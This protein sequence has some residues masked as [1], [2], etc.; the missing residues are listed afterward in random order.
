S[1][2]GGAETIK[3]LREIDSAVKAIVSSG[4]SDDADVSSYHELGFLAFL[5][6]PY[7]AEKLQKI[8]NEVLSR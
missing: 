8:M 2:M 7:D 6:K 3:A 5:K 1:G 4:Y